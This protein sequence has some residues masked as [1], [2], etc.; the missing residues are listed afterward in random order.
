MVAIG[1]GVGNGYP[2]SVT[3]I[4]NRTI[5]RIGKTN[6]FLYSKSHQNDP[7]AIIGCNDLIKYWTE[8]N[9][10]M[11]NELHN[12]PMKLT[13]F[14]HGICTVLR[15]EANPTPTLRFAMGQAGNLFGR[16]TLKIGKSGNCYIVD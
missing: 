16:Y 12:K 14:L 15:S 8:N 2:V 1:K 10:I 7:L 13:V 3:A 11:E 9:Y 5:K 4:N 6:T